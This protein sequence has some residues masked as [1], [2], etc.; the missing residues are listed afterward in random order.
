MNIMNSTFS[1]LGRT[2]SGA[3]L[4]VGLILL[5]AISLMAIASMN[6]ATLD[7]VMAGNEQYRSRAFQAAEAAIEVALAND[8]AFDTSAAFST[9]E[10]IPFGDDSYT[11]EVVSETSGTG[12]TGTPD[13]HTAGKFVA[14]FFKITATGESLR[15]AQSVHIQEA[16]QVTQNSDEVTCI[17]NLP[18]A[19]L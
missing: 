7:L 18:C 14:I 10:P 6:T 2:Q 13:G 1:P 12:F 8:D 11:Y 16:Y 15:G 5:V 19:A 3:A 9:S 17:P 4:V